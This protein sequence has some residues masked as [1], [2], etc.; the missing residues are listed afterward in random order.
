VLPIPDTA[1]EL[2]FHDTTKAITLGGPRATIGWV[3]LWR[4]IL[5]CDVLDDKPVLRD[6]PLPKPMR[7]NKRNF[8]IGCPHPYRDITVVK[9][10][11]QDIEIKYVEMGTRPG[12]DLPPRR[13]T[14]NS[15]NSDYSDSDD[16]DHEEECDFDVSPYWNAAV[17]TMP[18]PIASWKDW[19]RDKD[20]K[21][22]VT[23]IVVD[24]P[25]HSELLLPLPRLSTDPEDATMS[26]RRLLTAHPTLG[27]GEDGD[28]VIYLLSKVDYMDDRG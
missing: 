18:V 12:E 6:V 4:G 16:N 13:S 8:C 27:L 26:L 19:H 15:N 9:L 17:W 20:C 1:T 21:V 14:D 24:N 25:R 23:D 2:L 10:S 28:V 22:D 5:L 11:E 7:I 3:D